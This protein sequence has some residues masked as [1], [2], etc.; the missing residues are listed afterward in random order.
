V[1]ADVDTDPTDDPRLPPTPQGWTVV[2]TQGLGPFTS[3][4]DY[5]RPDGVE[6]EWTSRRHRKGQG[7]QL[8]AAPSGTVAEIHQVRVAR[9]TY[10]IAGLFAVGSV[11]FA[12]G[13]LPFYLDAV[14][15]RVDGLT[16]FI[17]SLFFT[18]ASYLSY[19]EVANSPDAILPGPPRHRR[20]VPSRWR[21]HSIDWWATGVQLIGTFY[22]N[23]MTFLALY[24]N[25][26]LDQERRLVWRPDAVGSICF[27]IASYLA[28]AEVCG[29]AGR[30]RIR[31]VSWWIVVLNLL[32]SVAFGVSAIG[33][34]VLSNGDVVSVRADNGGTIVGAVCFFVAALLLIPEASTAR[35]PVSLDDLPTLGSGL[36]GAGPSGPQ[37]PSP[38]TAVP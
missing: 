38:D 7:L 30:L 24:D 3:R 28:W 10:W 6:V 31:D 34:F 15:P 12:L 16:F 17:G 23:V 37:A 8:V 21:P 1:H 19:A 4:V 32:G 22:F 26:S 2:S 18:A 36:P 14:S 13:S 5:R 25:W 11:C 29:N 35:T 27:L 33:A 20:F 9:R